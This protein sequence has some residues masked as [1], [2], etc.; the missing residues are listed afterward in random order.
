MTESA[1]EK[2]IA[3]PKAAVAN[4]VRAAMKVAYRRRAAEQPIHLGYLDLGDGRGIL[5]LPAE[6]FIEYQ[7]GAQ[8]L[9]PGSFL[10]T[11]AYGDGGPWYIP[12]AAAYPQ[13]G[14]EPTMSWVDPGSEEVLKENVRKLM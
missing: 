2:L 9:R 11:A 10:A 8:K 3:D 6:C 1:L 12:T 4:R 13:G 14:Y 5:H 7:L